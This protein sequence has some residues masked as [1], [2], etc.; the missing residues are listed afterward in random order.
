LKFSIKYILLGDF[1]I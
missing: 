1:D